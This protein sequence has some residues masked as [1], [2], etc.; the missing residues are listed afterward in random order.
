[1]PLMWRRTWHIAGN[2]MKKHDLLKAILMVPFSLLVIGI[3]LLDVWYGEELFLDLWILY[4]PIVI[5]LFALFIISFAYT[6]WRLSENYKLIL[7]WIPF[8]VLFLFLLFYIFAPVVKI[9]NKLNYEL[10]KDKRCEVV[11]MVTAHVM[12]PEQNSISVKVPE[13]YKGISTGGDIAIY[14]NENE[15]VVGFWINRGFLDS[16]YSMFLYSS[17]NDMNSIRKQSQDILEADVIEKI[18]NH[19]FYMEGGRD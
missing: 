1:M 19:W 10:Y 17:S 18:E 9:R 16:G 12:Q 6:I 2:T 8:I 15:V 11:D 7:N 3:I 14:S 13:E 5:F 4:V